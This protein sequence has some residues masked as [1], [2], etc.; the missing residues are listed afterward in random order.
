LREDFEKSIDEE[1]KKYFIFRDHDE[2]YQF[3]HDGHTVIL[4]VMKKLFLE[5]KYT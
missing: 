4:L 3:Y 2:I 1:G 5:S